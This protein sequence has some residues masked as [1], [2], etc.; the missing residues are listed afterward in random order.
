MPITTFKQ[1]P[2]DLAEWDRFFRQVPVEPDPG[3]VGTD[4]LENEGITEGKIAT[5]AIGNTR[6]RDS[7]ACSL[8]GRSTNTAGD[9][10][11]IVIGEAEFLVRRSNVVSSSTILDADLPASIARDSEVTAGDAATAATAAAAL[12]A[13]VAAADPHPGYTTAAELAT[14]IS[15][16]M[17]LITSGTYTP[18][19]TNVANLDASTAY[20]CQ[21][22]RVDA[23]VTVS[24]RVDVDPTTTLTSTQLGISLPVA[25]NIGAVE[26]CAG[27]AYASGIA[28]QG[29]AILGDAANNRAQMQWVAADVTNQAMYFT[30]SYQVI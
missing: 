21:Y 25:S 18:T 3:S 4:E 24:G 2:R 22:L 5:N 17:S 15:N 13:H 19:L 11:D 7:A 10:A 6:L 9:P 30:F 12:S 26:D 27:T 1:V 23:T 28:A 29:A 8:I 14:A 20:Q 16:A